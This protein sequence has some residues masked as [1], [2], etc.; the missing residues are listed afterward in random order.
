MKKKVNRIIPETEYSSP[1]IAVLE[2]STENVVCQSYNAQGLQDFDVDSGTMVDES[3]V[4]N[5]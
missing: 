4:W 2:F 1:E 3:D 5:F